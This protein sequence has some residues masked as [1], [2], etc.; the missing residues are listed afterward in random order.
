MSE[1]QHP[2]QPTSGLTKIWSKVDVTPPAH[3]RAMDGDFRGTA[4]NPTFQIRRATELWGPMGFGWGFDVMEESFEQ[5]APLGVTPSGESLGFERHHMLRGRLWFM[6]DGVRGEVEQ[7][8]QTPFVYTSGERIVTE[9]DVKKKSTTDAMMKCLSLLGFSA[10]VYMGR[11]DDSKYVAGLLAQQDMAPAPN[12]ARG[13]LP[14]VEPEAQPQPAERV[15]QAHDDAPDATS[16]QQADGTAGG[17]PASAAQGE[18]II[19]AENTSHRGEDAA[20]EALATERSQLQ[21]SL[22]DPWLRRVAAMGIDGLSMAKTTVR[23]VL[24]GA[25]LEEVET[26][27]ARREQQLSSQ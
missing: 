2:E 23:S 1:K 22:V 16:A 14:A 12:A 9:S 13:L 11:Y 5:G 20:A 19:L 17:S 26:A 4:I 24:S 21:V 7:Y 15:Q 27:I 18:V 10:D 3:T 6:V 8:G 25:A